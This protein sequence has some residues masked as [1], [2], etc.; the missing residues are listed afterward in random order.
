M[1]TLQTT[2]E[3]GNGTDEAPVENIDIAIHFPIFSSLADREGAV[4]LVTVGNGLQTFN[5]KLS[6]NT[7]SLQLPTSALFTP[8]YARV[9][10]D[11]ISYLGR[12][13]SWWISPS[14]IDTHHGVQAE[15]LWFLQ[16]IDYQRLPSAQQ[17]RNSNPVL[18]DSGLGATT[19]D[20]L[21]D[22]P[23][24][25]V[26]GEGP[27]EAR[28]NRDIY[29]VNKKVYYELLNKFFPTLNP[30]AE[31]LLLYVINLLAD[32]LGP[33]PALTRGSLEPIRGDVKRV[34][35]KF[36]AD[37]PGD[38]FGSFVAEF[39]RLFDFPIR[40]ETL[41]PLVVAGNL[42][43]NEPIPSHIN[44]NLY[45]LI[46]EFTVGSIEDGIQ[47]D[48]VV[49]VKSY[50]G[51]DLYLA[52][53]QPSDRSLQAL[54]IKVDFREPSAIEKAPRGSQR[55]P[56]K[57]IRGKVV[58]LWKTC[59][60]KATIVIQ[61]KTTPDGP[62]VTVST[63][64]SDKAGNFV[65][66]YPYG[67][68][69][70]A[71]ARSSLDVS[72]ATVIPVD[73]SKGEES[74]SSEFLYMTLQIDANLDKGDK[75]SSTS[76][77]CDEL[78][79]AGRLPS[80][81]DLLQ[82]DQF[83]QDI[84]GGCINLSVPNR[85]LR[86]YSH[87][88][89]VR[90]TD[91]DVANY[92]MRSF[93]A[94]MPGTDKFKQVIYRLVSHGKINRRQIDL[95][96]PVQWQDIT[97][98]R[99]DMALSQAVTVAT[100]HI[101]HYRSEFRADGYS[102]GDLIYSLPLAPGQKKQIITMDSAHS[103]VG[104]ESQA[105]DQSED[106]AAYLS[107]DRII[108]DDI[109]GNIGE[110][111]DG[112]SK[113]S[114]SGWGASGGAAGGT[115]MVG[116]TIGISGGASQSSSSAHQNSA[117]GLAQH[118]SEQLKQQML[119][120]SSSYRA[121]NSTVVT[122][123]Q[124]NQKYKAETTV[125]A[126]HNHCHSLTLL[127]FEVLRHY[128][129]YQELVDVEECV[130]VP[131]LM[132]RF[133]LDN[134]SKWADVLAPRLL[135]LRANTSLRP[136][137][138]FMK[139]PAHPLLGAF[140]AAE[141]VRTEWK[142]VDYPET[143]YDQEV[144]EWVEGEMTLMT[145]IPRPKTRYDF[146]MSLPM[147]YKTVVHK[148]FDTETAVKDTLIKMSP[149]GPFFD[150]DGTVE[151][152]EQV[153]SRAQIFD[154]FMQLDGNYETVPPSRCIRIVNFDPVPA[155]AASRTRS[156]D[157]VADFFKNDTEDWK[158]WRAYAS[159]LGHTGEDGVREML[160]KYFLR[161]L[162]G[163]WD[164]IFNRGIA[165]L[166]YKHFVD[167]LHIDVFGLMDATLIN[168]YNGGAKLMK[169]AFA[170]PASVVRRDIHT[171]KVTSVSETARSLNKSLVRFILQR[172]RISYS[173]T[174]YHGLLYNGS[175]RGDVLDETGATM[176]TPT[177][178][179]EKRNPREEDR[180]LCQRLMTHLN[181]NLE[182]YNRILW[183][184]LDPQ[185][186]Y[187]LLDGFHIETFKRNGD[188]D[189]FR[190]LS[191]VVKNSLIAVV[192]NTMVFPVAP[193]YKVDQ[194][195]IVASSSSSS[196][197]ED[198]GGDET[199]PPPESLLDHYKSELMPPPYRLSVPSRGVYSEAIMGQC[200]SCEKVQ[201]DTS[202]DWTKFQTDEPTAVAA[203]TPP[204]PTITNYQPTIKDF[205]PP[206]VAIQ[207]TP[208]LPDPAAGLRAATELLGKTGL[209]QDVT[210]LSAN[211]KNALEALVASQANAN[212]V[213]QG[214]LGAP[215]AS[216]ASML[217]SQ[218]HNTSNASRIMDAIKS[219][220]DSKLITPELASKLA[221]DSIQAQ[222]DGGMTKRAKME[223]RKA[224]TTKPILDAGLEGAR[225][226]R[227]VQMHTIKA[228]GDAHFVSIGDRSANIG[229]AIKVAV[230]YSADVPV[231]QQKGETCWAYV[232]AMMVSWRDKASL[233]PQEALEPAGQ[234]WVDRL[235]AGLGIDDLDTPEFLP[236]VGMVSEEPASYPPS[237]YVAK[238]RMYGP[239]WITIELQRR[240]PGQKFFSVH[241]L[242]L[243]KIETDGNDNGRRTLF[244]FIDPARGSLMTLYFSDFVD[245]YE[246][247][248]KD[249]PAP[250]PMDPQ[251][252]H[253]A[254]PR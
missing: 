34:L 131:L 143:S 3:Y 224:A 9:V 68:Y 96:N 75:S 231:L 174:R 50:D 151:V 181:Q 23:G 84:G 177:T 21:P 247:L 227:D 213:A 70:E 197:P 203:V 79:R 205:A 245:Y 13:S 52:S 214:A 191:S 236:A 126:N 37:P 6:S 187:L 99:A 14:N 168:N 4:S 146:I 136:A 160:N 5:Q 11:Y 154:S 156:F 114:T 249:L 195:L 66:P 161:Q 204:V 190:S 206:L 239:L 173:T 135:P 222:I 44:F 182:F 1:L 29:L 220:L 93:E 22:I 69:T 53:F 124:E 141:R 172:L 132:T 178:A 108:I 238:M 246:N 149:L 221:G 30:E 201:P 88:T 170:A 51:S 243:V 184:S 230:D 175:V 186:R 89:L 100:G 193:G 42:W 95:D 103:L 244:T 118:F 25:E 144:I 80:N 40:L 110:S 113:A 62:W 74:M 63:G 15:A 176:W 147:I 185:R 150:G 157:P 120:N 130:F 81:D 57:K 36:G 235:N 254:K 253:F 129:V 83:M 171:L 98:D 64:T 202:Q 17:P 35:A 27:A 119:Q 122:A 123:V 192:G 159:I 138:Q 59:T 121:R 28:I 97:D 139:K 2:F 207:N 87:T 210:G 20:S 61:A 78:A 107:N 7:Y 215:I 77:S 102:L 115:G 91:P 82:S 164:D 134:I 10:G 85:T 58:S 76:C 163:D 218:A 117:R 188:S 90:H 19:T 145:D 8:Q 148:E 240:P 200:D 183:Y 229:R 112:E 45:K 217:A 158:M 223:E 49:R 216:M 196:S 169:V 179:A 233:T 12:R 225:N 166:V 228:D 211:Q 127:Y 155:N 208:A 54:T 137:T 24:T 180:F 140:D 104:S 199:P 133:T 241:A 48:V 198:G 189:S 67:T 250:Y 226:D 65:L 232:V 71:A 128:A 94:P 212:A 47:G 209:F 18:L 152:R 55:D 219:A 106:V 31:S 252:T 167:S 72:N 38:F 26:W 111:L 16:S 60:L 43:V 39:P 92:T 153:A 125:V 242:V 237:V 41:R 101:L 32:L 73:P 162:I 194:A 109:A 165:P 251:I 56:A 46:A 248:A 33:S 234:K 105:V 142:M 116:G 86:E